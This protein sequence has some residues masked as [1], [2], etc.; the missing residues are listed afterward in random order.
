MNRCPDCNKFVSLENGEPEFNSCEA[1]LQNGDVLVTVSM[2][3][4]RNCADC[5]TEMKSLES[6]MEENI[7]IENFDG[8]KELSDED[9]TKLLKFAE[10]DDETIELEAEENEA[11]MDEAGGGRYAKNMITTTAKVDVSL[12]WDR[13][14]HGGEVIL[15]HTLDLTSENAAS[16]FE[17]CC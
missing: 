9:K 7:P 17:E 11:S 10:E 5:G 2:R 12:T 4:I 13:R 8:F 16:E 14:A 1:T 6:E 15:T 3:S